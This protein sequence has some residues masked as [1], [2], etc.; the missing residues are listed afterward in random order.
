VGQLGAA[1]T[2]LGSDIIFDVF[3][4]AVIGGVSLYG[5][6]GSMIGALGGVLLL[7]EISTGLALLNVSQFMIDAIRGFI[8]L[9]AVTVDSLLVLRVRRHRTALAAR[10]R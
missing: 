7:G 2:A 10:M 1:S 8:I 4:A 6:K 9:G 5:G 3:A